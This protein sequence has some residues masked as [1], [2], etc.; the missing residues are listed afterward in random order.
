MYSNFIANFWKR[1][2]LQLFAFVNSK[3]GAGLYAT[4]SRFSVRDAWN[5]RG[6]RVAAGHQVQRGSQSVL[7]K[8]APR[9]D[10]GKYDSKRDDRERELMQVERFPMRYELSYISGALFNNR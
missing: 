1:S 7:Y 5:D 3:L 8:L 6:R 10:H 9:H 4:P 2:Y